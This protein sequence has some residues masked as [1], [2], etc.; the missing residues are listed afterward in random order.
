MKCL[1]FLKYHL[2]MS[3]SCGP[4][5]DMLCSYMWHSFTISAVLGKK[6]VVYHPSKVDRQWVYD[7]GNLLVKT[8]SSGYT[9]VFYYKQWLYAVYRRRP[10]GTPLLTI[11]FW[12]ELL[13]KNVSFHL[14][15]DSRDAETQFAHKASALTAQ[16]PR[17]PEIQANV[18]VPEMTGNH[19]WKQSI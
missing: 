11:W 16:E 18:W 12:E 6:P 2:D 13:E 9:V 19:L 5:R 14:T 1:Q 10:S 4:F 17:L 7:N 15:T 8:D 3:D